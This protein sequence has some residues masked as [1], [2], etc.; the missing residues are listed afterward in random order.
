MGKLSAVSGDWGLADLSL[1]L[2]ELTSH[3]TQAGQPHMLM[4]SRETYQ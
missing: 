3:H 4:I 1:S 2:P